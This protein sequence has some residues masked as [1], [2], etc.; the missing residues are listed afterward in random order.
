MKRPKVGGA[1]RKCDERC[2]KMKQIALDAGLVLILTG[3]KDSA[4]ERRVR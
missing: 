3:S 2:Q 4:M 1:L